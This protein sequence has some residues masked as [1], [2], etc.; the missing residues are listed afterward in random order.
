MERLERTVY[1][2]ELN[3]EHYY[4]GSLA[5]LYSKFTKEQLGV[6]YGTLRNYKIEKEK[7]YQ[8]AKCTLRKGILMTSTTPKDD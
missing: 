4:F 3:G 8:N 5:A 7:P 2:L 1:H 6:A